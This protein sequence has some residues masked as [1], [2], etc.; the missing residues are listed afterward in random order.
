M[1]LKRFGRGNINLS[2]AIFEVFL[3]L[4]IFAKNELCMN[5]NEFFIF[6]AI[7]DAFHRHNDDDN[8]SLPEPLPEN[9]WYV[10]GFFIILAIV[11]LFLI[12]G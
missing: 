5:W 6:N 3:F 7:C 11:L 2:P 9:N 10:T 12:L 1:R 8:D 4:Y